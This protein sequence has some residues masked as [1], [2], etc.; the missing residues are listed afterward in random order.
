MGIIFSRFY[1]FIF[2][3]LMFHFIVFF[4]ILIVLASNC[5]VLAGFTASFSEFLRFRF[6][7]LI[8]VFCNFTCV[9]GLAS[10]NL[11]FFFFFFNVILPF[12]SFN[13]L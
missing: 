12:L 1:Y 3:F 10:T 7:F 4:R 5:I 6:Y 8:T 13:V 11:T 9:L 2:L